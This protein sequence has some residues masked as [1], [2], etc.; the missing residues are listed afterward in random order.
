[1]S[2]LLVSFFT[3]PVMGVP[4]RDITTDRYPKLEAGVIE[5]LNENGELPDDHVKFSYPLE[6]GNWVDG[7]HKRHRLYNGY[8]SKISCDTTTGE[9]VFEDDCEPKKCTKSEFKETD[10]P[11]ENQVLVNGTLPKTFSTGDPSPV[12]CADG[13]FGHPTA[14]CYE[15]ENVYKILGVCMDETAFAAALE[16]TVEEMHAAPVVGRPGSFEYT[17]PEARLI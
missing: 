7:A 15:E 12:K 4:C 13:Y 11:R 1:M 6:C 2:I 16:M 17:K 9:L 3:L 5:A 10:Y 14:V 8:I